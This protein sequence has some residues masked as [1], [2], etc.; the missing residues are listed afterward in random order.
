MLFR[1]VECGLDGEEDDGEGEGSEGEEFDFDGENFD[2][3]FDMGA[4]MASRT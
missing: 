1:S 2:E 3:D 4:L